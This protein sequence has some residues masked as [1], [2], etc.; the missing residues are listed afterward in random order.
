MEFKEAIYNHFVNIE[1]EYVVTTSRVCHFIWL[2]RLLK[3]LWMSQEKPIK[4]YM[5]T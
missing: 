1:V 3:E 2:R 4:I 5:D